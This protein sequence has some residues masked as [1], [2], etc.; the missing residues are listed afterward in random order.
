MKPITITF[1]LICVLVLAVAVQA[2]GV[3]VGS[4]CKIQW[5]SNTESDLAKYTV[6]G[7]LT[8]NTAGSVP[9]TKA[10]DVL[11]PVATLATINITCAQIG[12]TT[13]GT[14]SIQVEAVDALGNRSAK[15][16]PVT[17][18]QD[19]TGPTTPS[20]VVIVPLQ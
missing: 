14:L 4:N 6:T 5:N 7:M 13:G 19:A 10:V 18:L 8:A 12:L 3:T 2:Q 9:L 20:G 15:S 11:K 1:S 16:S 17:A